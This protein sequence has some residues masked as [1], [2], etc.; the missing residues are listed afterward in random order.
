MA[1]RSDGEGSK[2]WRGPPGGYLDHDDARDRHL[3]PARLLPDVADLPLVSVPSE[4]PLE[5]IRRLGE[6]VAP[7]ARE[8]V[9]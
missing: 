6:E 1:P 9:G 5:F 2:G 3:E 4:E 8:L 7:R